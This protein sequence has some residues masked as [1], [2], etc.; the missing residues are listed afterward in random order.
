MQNGD[1]DRNNKPRCD[2]MGNLDFKSIQCR[3]CGERRYILWANKK[4]LTCQKC[5]NLYVIDETSGYEEPE[6]YWD[7]EKIVKE[8]NRRKD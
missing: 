1:S 7:G 3:R 6:A 4:G 5:G 8:N 2:G